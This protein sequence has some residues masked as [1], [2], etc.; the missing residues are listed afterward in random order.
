[1]E[2][3]NTASTY[4]HPSSWWSPLRYSV[5]RALWIASIA[6]NIGTWMQN[7]GAT[8]MMTSLAPSAFMVSLVQ[9]A[10]FLPV[11]L[12]G[13]PAGALA[14]LID[15]RKLLL[16]TQ[17]WML[18]A[19]ALLGILT[20][21]GNL[22]PWSLLGLSFF[23]GLGAAMNSPAWQ[24]IIFEMVPAHELP[25]AIALGSASFN[26]ARAVGPALGG[27]V[28]AALGP[29]ANFIL[30]AISFLTVILVLYRWKRK[31]IKNP[32]P[33][34]N[35]AGAMKAGLRYVR[36]SPSLHR[37]LIRTLAFVTPASAIWALLPVITH[38]ELKSGPGTYGLLLGCLGTGAVLGTLVL[39]YFRRATSTNRLIEV[40]IFLFA[41][42]TL[43]AAWAP[44]NFPLLVLA[45][46]IGGAAW[47]CTLSTLNTL[48]SISVP[49]WVRARALSIYLLIFFG[50]MTAGSAFWGIIASELSTSTSLTLAGICLF[51]SLAL[52]RPIRLVENPKEL[53][54]NPA[55]SWSHPYPRAP[56][57]S[58][59]LTP[60]LEQRRV[61]V[62]I[63]YQIDPSQAQHFVAAIT[64][65]KFIRKRNG[66]SRWDLFQ[67][68]EVAG[69]YLEV[70]W[71]DSWAEH[72]RQH[73][74]ITVSDQSI[75]D[76]VKSFHIAAELPKVT[77]LVSAI[78]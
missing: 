15:R 21:S 35:L 30:N 57:M 6:S 34:E 19:A 37:I 47:L 5:F 62:T 3:E 75:T 61:L 45:L 25:P 46:L 71:V 20:L 74:R 8:W 13:L 43:T 72:L 69:R 52:S 66:A 23:L 50:G 18:V 60:R 78:H 48:I 7:V 11:F 65:V 49:E 29:G 55:R 77:H 36:H 1:M 24:A 9:S 63:E 12:L 31:P 67:D 28:V 54:L 58:P 33:P 17:T 27:F 4:A 10:N 22:S 40:M 32:G 41:G 68:T 26:V 53:N 16:I 2:H 56:I 14:D 76:E 39:P 70:F 51:C 44:R 38:N 42:T 73:E 64:K 59:L